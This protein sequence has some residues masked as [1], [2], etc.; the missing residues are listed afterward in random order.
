VVEHRLDAG[1]GSVPRAEGVVVHRRD[2]AQLLADEADEHALGGHDVADQV[3]C[4]PVLTG[5]LAVPPVG[6]DGGD[7]LGEGLAET[8]IAVGDLAHLGEAIRLCPL[9]RPKTKSSPG[10][11]RSPIGGGGGP[12]TSWA[13]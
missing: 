2:V 6:W 11:T 8:A 3:A 9:R 5:G 10:S 4:G 13:R 12:P 1:P 7:L